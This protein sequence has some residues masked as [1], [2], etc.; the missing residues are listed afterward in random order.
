MKGAELFCPLFAFAGLPYAFKAYILLAHFLFPPV[1]YAAA[2]LL[3]LRRSAA[4]LALLLGLLFWHWGRPLLGH[5]RWAGMHSYVLASYLA[6]LALALFVHGF[7]TQG[8]SRRVCQALLV[9]LVAVAWQVHVLAALLLVPGFVAAYAAGFRRLRRS[10]HLALLAVLAL[11]LAANADW[12]LP[13]LRFRHYKTASDYWFQLHGL[14]D[15]AFL[16]S[17]ETSLLFSA[18][19]VLGVVG[20]VRWRRRRPLAAVAFGA[21]TLAWFL[22]AFFGSRWHVLANTEPG[23][24]LLPF[25][26]AM[27]VPAGAA[28]LPLVE[29]LQRRLGPALASALLVVVAS[30][31][32]ALA[33]ADAWFFDVHRIRARVDP[34]FQELLGF[35]RDHTSRDARL[36]FE[37]PGGFYNQSDLL[38]GGHLQALVPI[39]TGR[40][41]IGGPYPVNFMLHGEVDFAN[42]EL[43]GRKLRDWSTE[44]FARFLDTY[45]VGWAVC[46]SASARA[47]LDAREALA[48]PRADFDR[49]RVYEFRR[50]HSYVLQGAGRARSDYG[51]IE[52]DEV[53][54]DEVVL[55]YHW[56][57]TLR[58]EPP[59]P[60]DSVPIPGDPVGFIRVRPGG[61]ARFTIVNDY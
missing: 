40:E 56:L 52:V 36:L 49:F 54:G 58:T 46:W 57:E 30:L 38:Y 51:R 7:E 1:L 2:R 42:G 4:L 35:L 48:T 53:A 60:L 20:L 55:S 44:E 39:A 5:F 12:L 24:Y 31:A 17:R 37:T 22:A 13:A 28:L 23:R 25:A 45:N 27:T 32:P 16:Y 11:V 3:G 18:I 41:A 47:Y 29:R 15:I 59:L 61:V 43:L 34:R 9:P 21:S 10:D 33:V 14:R 26:L 19:T 6:L 8:R 50:L